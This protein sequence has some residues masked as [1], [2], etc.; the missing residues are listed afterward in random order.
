M[1]KTNANSSDKMAE[2]EKMYSQFIDQLV[3]EKGLDYLEADVL[4][5]VK[6]DLLE[7]LENKINAMILKNLPADT[8]SEFE[9]LLDD[10]KS[11]S[12]QMNEFL[13]K[14]IPSL[15]EKIAAELMQFR[16]VY[17]NA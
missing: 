15:T 9:K 10:E 16:N 14:Y 5:E 13:N 17:L 3:K 12:Q 6:V 7:R 1:N 8:L 2:V 4:E 11:D